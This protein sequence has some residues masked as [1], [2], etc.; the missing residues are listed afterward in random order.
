MTGPHVHEVRAVARRIFAICHASCIFAEKRA[1]ENIAVVDGAAALVV[2]VRA[3]EVESNW[4]DTAS[5]NRR[6][7]QFRWQETPADAEERG[8]LRE[9]GPHS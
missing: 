8:R 4:L 2:S 6:W 1:R 9:F 7:L 3:D 5:W